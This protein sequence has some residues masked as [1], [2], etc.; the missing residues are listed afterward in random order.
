MK[1]C[2]IQKFQNLIFAITTKYEPNIVNIN[3]F[4]TFKYKTKLLGNVIVDGAD[5]ILKN[6]TFVVPLQYLINFWR[7]LEMP[8]INCKVELKLK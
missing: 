7:S 6:I 2:I 8:L 5:G 3:D 1:L 4:K